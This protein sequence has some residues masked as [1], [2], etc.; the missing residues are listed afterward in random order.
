MEELPACPP[1]DVSCLR[2]TLKELDAHW[3]KP[4]VAG[5]LAGSLM[6]TEEA[7]GKTVCAL[8]V[9]SVR[10]LCELAVWVSEHPALVSEQ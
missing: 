9:R 8:T 6:T 10:V 3:K 4:E 1:P 7:E 5:Q 2:Q